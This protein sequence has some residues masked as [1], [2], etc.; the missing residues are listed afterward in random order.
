MEARPPNQP[1]AFKGRLGLELGSESM[2]SACATSRIRDSRSSVLSPSDCAENDATSAMRPRG[3]FFF[4]GFLLA[5]STA[6]SYWDRTSGR[7]V[8]SCLQR[9]ILSPNLITAERL[10]RELVAVTPTNMKN[11]PIPKSLAVKSVPP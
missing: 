10:S 8:E 7:D 9:C 6:S 2:N 4:Y 3:C 5:V 11:V 1:V